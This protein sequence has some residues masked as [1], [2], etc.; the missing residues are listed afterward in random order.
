MSNLTNFVGSSVILPDPKDRRFDGVDQWAA[1]VVISD[2]SQAIMYSLM[3]ATLYGRKYGRELIRRMVYENRLSTAQLCELYCEQL[4]DVF[5]GRPLIS[6]GY[7]HGLTTPDGPCFGMEA[8]FELES[9][10]HGKHDTAP[11]SEDLAWL[12][13]NAARLSSIPAATLLRWS[14]SSIADQDDG[15]L[16]HAEIQRR[17]SNKIDLEILKGKVTLAH[18]SE[19]LHK[20]IKV[21]PSGNAVKVYITLILGRRKQINSEAMRKT[22]KEAIESLL[23][24]SGTC[25]DPV[26]TLAENLLKMYLADPRVSKEN[27]DW[28]KEEVDRVCQGIAKNFTKFVNWATPKDTFKITHDRRF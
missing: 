2:N 5:K 19:R 11:C 17:V 25:K 20:A 4:D 18:L 28:M 27:T 14:I 22:V 26:Y 8:I 16:I 7:L 1:A 13:R 21:M 24:A 6:L 10:R 23:Y 15:A 3:V 9:S 12:L